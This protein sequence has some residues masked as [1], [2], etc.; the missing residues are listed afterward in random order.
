MKVISKGYYPGTDNFREGLVYRLKND[1][2]KDKRL[3]FKVINDDYLIN[4][5]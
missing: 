2:N 4:K 1:W 5:K 3:S